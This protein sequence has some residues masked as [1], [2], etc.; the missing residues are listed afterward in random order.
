MAVSGKWTLAFV[1]LDCHERPD[2]SFG[3]SGS[4]ALWG[5][6]LEQNGTSVSGM[7]T[8]S[9]ANYPLAG[10]LAPDGTMDLAGNV[11]RGDPIPGRQGMR[12]WMVHWSP[13]TLTFN[14]TTEFFR[15]VQDSTGCSE[16]PSRTFVALLG[17][18]VSRSN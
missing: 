13:S 3:C 2:I 5:L 7:F 1:G 8:G 18:D 11:C 17:V 14:G 10:H 4:K 15:T 9:A 6:D 16:N 12:N